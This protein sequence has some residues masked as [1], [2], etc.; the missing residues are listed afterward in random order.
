MEEVRRVMGPQTQSLQRASCSGGSG[1]RSVGLNFNPHNLVERR[2]R[3]GKRSSSGMANTP[4][5]RSNK[6]KSSKATTYM[7]NISIFEFNENP[8]AKKGFTFKESKIVI[9]GVIEIDLEADEDEV[10]RVIAAIITNAT[11]DEDDF[12]EYG[13]D[14]FEFVKRSGHTFRVPDVAPGFRF[15]GGALKTVAG[16]GDVYVRLTKSVPTVQDQSTW[17]PDSDFIE[18]APYHPVKQ[19]STCT[20]GSSSSTPSRKWRETGEPSTATVDVDLTLGSHDPNNS[21]KT[22]MQFW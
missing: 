19:S 16:Q 1:S 21:P 22:G 15:S 14:D 2:S 4:Q 11:S 17:S 9:S 12:S 18:E 8:A 6:G 13:P 3:A 7:K 5:S 10:R 20:A